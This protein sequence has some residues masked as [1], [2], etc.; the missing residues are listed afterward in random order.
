MSTNE[1]CLERLAPTSDNQQLL[2]KS[3]KCDA[4]DYMISATCGL[5]GG[6]VDIFLVGAPRDSVIGAWTDAQVDKCVVQFAKIC[7]WKHDPSKENNVIDAIN[8]LGNKF[9]VNYDQTSITLFKMNPQNHHM[10]SLGHSPDP[11]GLFF[12]ILNQF[13]STSSFVTNGQV[14]TI[15]TETHELQ[16]N[17][18][19]SKLFCGIVNWI[20][21]LMSDVAGHE[22]TRKKGRRGMGITMPFFEMFELLNVGSFGNKKTLADIAEAVYT[23]KLHG[24]TNTYD[25]RFGLTQMIP[26]IICELLIDLI[27]TLRRF[28]Q[29]KLPFKECIPTSKHSDLRRMQLIGNGTLCLIDGGEATLKS[30]LKGGNLIVFISRLN[31]MAWM[32]LVRLVLRE[33]RMQL[34]LSGMDEEIEAYILINKKLDEYL[35]ELKRIDIERFKE[36]TEAYNQYEDIISSATTPEVLNQALI[37]MYDKLGIDVS[38]KGHDSFDS[39]MRDKN[40]VMR[41]E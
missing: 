4:F 39:F 1:V 31:Y 6:M 16:G 2:L 8:F 19:L 9:L 34:G 10:K 18:F 15:S 3:G 7:K 26:V 12:S 25:F 41:F 24:N 40:A 37:D 29:Y 30:R 17:N 11:I 35:A 22:T 20:G 36:E 13:T 38:W 23:D 14:I 32:N 28:F 5:I 21:H 27:W 33:L